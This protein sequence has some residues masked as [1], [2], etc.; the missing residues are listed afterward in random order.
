MQQ[1]PNQAST[2]AFRDAL[3]VLRGAK[4]WLLVLLLLVLLLDVAAFV[5]VRF[6]SALDDSPSFAAQVRV[7]QFG[8]GA[9]VG[10]PVEASPAEADVQTDPPQATMPTGDEGEPKP[11]RQDGQAAG[12]PGDGTTATAPAATEPPADAV[13][14]PAAPRMTLEPS[15]EADRAEMV[16]QMLDVWLPIIRL[17][18]VIFAALLAAVLAVSTLVSAAG[19]LKGVAQITG[20]MIW[21]FWLMAVVMPWNAMFPGGQAVRE[22]VPG[23]LF[24]LPE[25]IHKT[26]LVTWGA[27]DVGWQELVIYYGRFVGWPLVALL[28][29]L[30]VAV[31][32]ARGYGES[33]GQ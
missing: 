25:L 9:V 17:A 7:A 2:G 18:G 3:G 6:T 4:T 23:V 13:P 26:A 21:S 15:K 1:N 8:A 19:G 31:K 14:P 29:W 12:Q 11:P 33:I 27:G 5:M 20:A 30:L 28:L 32:F 22:L 16:Y 24:D 10:A